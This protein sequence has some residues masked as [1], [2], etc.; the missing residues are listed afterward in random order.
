M[1]DAMW[2]G[3]KVLSMAT[4]RA[5]SVSSTGI[6]A[7]RPEALAGAAA[8]ALPGSYRRVKEHDDPHALSQVAY[9]E[10]WRHKQ[11]LIEA[12]KAVGKPMAEYVRDL[13]RA[14][15][16]KDCGLQAPTD[17]PSQSERLEELARRKGLTVKQLKERALEELLNKELSTDA[18]RKLR[19]P[20]WN[21]MGNGV[22]RRAAK[23]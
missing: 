7:L 15:S 22:V 1:L 4:T 14:Q 12:A 5:S 9:Q 13:I 11:V 2:D 6:K 17:E 3:G 16:Y 23:R 21:P 20:T 8:P 10:E 19:E 18:H